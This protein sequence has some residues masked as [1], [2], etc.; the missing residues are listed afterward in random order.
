M[1]WKKRKVEIY[2]VAGKKRLISYP[3][4]FFDRTS[5]GQKRYVHL[6]VSGFSE[7]GL[8]VALQAIRLAHYG[9]NKTDN[10]L[11]TRITIVDPNMDELKASFMSQFRHLEQI[12]D[13]DT[14]V[15]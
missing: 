12:Y 2:D 4:L 7:M 14:S 9:N 11:R 15:S 13:L 1:F 5:E 3:S 10:S 8:A 6:V